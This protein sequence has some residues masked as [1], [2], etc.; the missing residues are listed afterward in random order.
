MQ[1]Y[2]VLLALGGLAAI[3]VF[4]ASAQEDP[5]KTLT[6]RL[7]LE[8]YKATIKDLT[9][10]GDRREGT[11]S[12][13]K[14]LEWIQKQLESHRCFTDR[15]RF[16]NQS[17]GLREQVF[18]TKIGASGSEEMYIVAAHMDGP[19]GSESTDDNASGTA[20]VL[21]LARIFSMS[22]VQTERSIR[23]VFWNNGAVGHEGLR[24]YVNQR[25]DLQG[26]ED[27]PGSGSYP[28]ARWLGFIDLDMVLGAGG[29]SRRDV[30]IQYQPASKYGDPSM[31]LA[32]FFRDANA[33][34]ATDYPAVVTPMTTPLTTP[35]MDLIPTIRIREREHEAENMTPDVYSTYA[36]DD[37]RLGLNTAQTTLGAIG[38]LAGAKLKK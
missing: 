16:Q 8:K 13:R 6:S 31:K 14:A 38:Q 15:L 20:I 19:G 9:E 5:V 24:A 23:F 11:E 2:R 4:T 32:N 1:L 33:I 34:Y 27:Y 35:F 7:D 17:D 18:C 3:S 28:E 29:G 30:N 26:K 12:N 37:F 21:E 36:D 25:M 10:F 22:D